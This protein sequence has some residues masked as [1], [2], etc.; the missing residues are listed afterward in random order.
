LAPR[1]TCAVA[2]YLEAPVE[3][4]Y[5]DLVKGEHK[6]PGYLAINPNGKV[7]TLVDDG[8]SL[9]E[10]DAIICRFAQRTDSDLWPQGD[11]QFDVLR[12]LSW[13]G[14]HF[15]RCC[16]ALYFEHIVKPR[17][18]LGEPNPAAVAEALRAFRANAE[19]LNR[20]LQGRKWLVNDNLSVA[21]FSVAVGLP[22]AERASMPLDEFPEICRWHDQLN[23][24]AAW[25]TPFPASP[26]SLS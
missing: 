25:R 21:D 5:V 6:A 17:F 20:H 11:R 16:G 1:K 18:G 8:E 14:Y 13:N 10:A 2:K 7:P 23:D 24:L 4:A 26:P 12:W 15:Y 3:Y 19:V 9:W 22:Y